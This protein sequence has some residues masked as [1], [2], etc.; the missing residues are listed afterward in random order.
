MSDAMKRLQQAKQM[1][2]MG[3]LNE[4]E[5]RLIREQVERQEGSREREGVV[6]HNEKMQDVFE[7]RIEQEDSEEIDEK[8]DNV[9]KQDIEDLEALLTQFASQAHI[10]E[11]LKRL[12]FTKDEVSYF[13]FR[14]F[15]EEHKR[16]LADYQS[17]S[18]ADPHRQER[19]ALRH[20]AGEKHYSSV[21]TFTNDSSYKD[22]ETEVK[23]FPIAPILNWLQDNIVED[24]RSHIRANPPLPTRDFAVSQRRTIRTTNRVAIEHK[25]EEQFLEMIRETGK[26]KFEPEDEVGFAPF[27]ENCGWKR[28]NNIKF[29][30]E[31]GHAFP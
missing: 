11:S 26:D 7:E 8:I 28:E 21:F 12:R 19:L 2:D 4:E 14:Y 27:C 20:F 24:P 1:L 13:L 25:L 31:C 17:D 23:D 15:I 3:L 9:Y 18:T 29:C 5:Y 16:R 30:M 6:N 22:F 10:S